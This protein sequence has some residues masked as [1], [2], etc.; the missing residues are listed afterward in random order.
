MRKITID[1]INPDQRVSSQRIYAPQ[2]AMS[3]AAHNGCKRTATNSKRH[4]SF[5]N[6]FT[7]LP[8]AVSD[9]ALCESRSA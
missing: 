2:M 3:G 5:D 7:I 4:I 1:P 8:G 6:K 9:K